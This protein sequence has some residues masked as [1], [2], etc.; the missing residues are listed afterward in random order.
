M[1]Y[2]GADKPDTKCTV[3]DVVGKTAEQANNAITGAGLIMK[4][5]GDTSGSSGSVYV[6]SQSVAAGEEVDAGTVIEVRLT[7]TSLVD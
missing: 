4:V 3:P 2:L 5:T 1:L 6:L 7:D